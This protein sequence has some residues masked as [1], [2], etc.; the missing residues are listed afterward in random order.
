MKGQIPFEI[1]TQP[2]LVLGI[3][4]SLIVLNL[5]IIHV[6]VKEIYY[7]TVP[8]SFVVTSKATLINTTYLFFF[9]TT[10]AQMSIKNTD[11]ESG[12]F[13]FDFLFTKGVER[14]IKR[15]STSILPGEE[16]VIQADAPSQE[17]INVSVV[18]P[19]KNVSHD[20]LIEKYVTAWNFLIH[21]Y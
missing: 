21:N 2:R 20:K 19:T 7:E 12:N 18:P 9:P 5:P 10:K 17:L 4:I 3:V 15:E 16:K 8:L 14:V 1:L 11:T 13:Y 6:E